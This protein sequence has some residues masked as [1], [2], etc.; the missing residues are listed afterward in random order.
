MFSCL[1]ILFCFMVSKS[2]FTSCQ[3]LNRL[4]NRLNKDVYYF[5]VYFLNAIRVGRRRGAN[6]YIRY[7]P[8]FVVRIAGEGNGFHVFAFSFLYGEQHIGGATA[9]AD[10]QQHVA[11]LTYSGDVAGKD[12]VE[13]EIVPY[14]GKVGRIVDGNTRQRLPV[15]TVSSGQLFGKMRRVAERSAIAAADDLVA[16]L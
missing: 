12:V 5:N 11:G 3:L 15:F 14:A 7:L 16:L 10:A 4:L 8:Q 1:I 6:G 9:R 13:R 2:R